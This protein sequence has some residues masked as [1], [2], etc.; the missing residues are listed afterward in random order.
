MQSCCSGPI[1]SASS[2]CSPIASIRFVTAVPP[3]RPLQLL[4][5]ASLRPLRLLFPDFN[6]SPVACASAAAPQLCPLRLQ[7]PD[8]VRFGCC[9]PISTA[10]QL[11]ALQLLLP[12]CVRFDY[13]SPIACASAAAPRLHALR[14]L[15]PDCIR[16]MLVASPVLED[17]SPC[18]VLERSPRSSRFNK[19]KYKGRASL[20]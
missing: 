11:R 5:A 7:L 10:P 17:S 2:C 3:F 16:L 19:F 18:L 20:V 13:S 6:S 12:D 15:L 14:L 9:S 1:A 8:C 4:L